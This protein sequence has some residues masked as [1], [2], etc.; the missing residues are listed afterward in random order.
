M[1]NFRA[2]IDREVTKAF[3][4][5]LV[6]GE[7]TEKVT[8]QYFQSAGAYD[9]V[10]DTTSVVYED[11]EADVIVSK[12]TED[13]AKDHGIIRSDTKLVLPG[14]ALPTDPQVDTDKVLRANGEVWDIRR[15]VGVP[16]R[17]IVLVFI[18]RT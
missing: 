4:N 1:T 11:V 2:L 15:T 9:P 10:T 14:S 18:Y 17:G 8:F 13:D 7:L 12:P 3:N 16:G 5:L 6:P